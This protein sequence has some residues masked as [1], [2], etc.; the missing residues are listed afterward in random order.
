MEHS[1]TK[2]A[3][4][5]ISATVLGLIDRGGNVAANVRG[6]TLGDFYG[7]V[8]GEFSPLPISE[9]GNILS[10][11]GSISTTLLKLSC[12][13]ESQ[14]ERARETTSITN[15]Q[16]DMCRWSNISSMVSLSPRSEQ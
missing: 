12:N 9:Q 13:V 5:V 16:D 6:A 14:G 10:E 1:K 11:S 8:I 4:S 2:A 15:P 3:S 7:A